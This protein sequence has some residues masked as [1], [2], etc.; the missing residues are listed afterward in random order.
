LAYFYVFRA[1]SPIFSDH[2]AAKLPQVMITLQGAAELW[3]GEGECARPMR[4]ASTIGPTHVA[5]RIVA[6]DNAVILGAGLL[7]FGWSRFVGEDAS[8]LADAVV[9][10]ASVFGPSADRLYERLL[11]SGAD[12]DRIDLLSRFFTG[13]RAHDD[14]QERAIAAIDAWLSGPRPLAIEA[15]REGLGVSRRSL[16]RLSRRTHG[17]PPERLA[18]KYRALRSA[19]RWAIDPHLGWRDAAETDFYDQPHFIREFRQFIGLTPRR[20]VAERTLVARLT[21]EGRLRAGVAS[22]LARCS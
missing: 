6:T 3:P 9:N 7:P 19:A 5:T 8:C 13:M 15:L 22:R 16:Q 18:R 1:N 17:A 20:F 12:Q 4:G 2:I 11:A 10:A 14:A 21:L